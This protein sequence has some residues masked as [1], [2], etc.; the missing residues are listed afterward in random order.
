M[1]PERVWVVLSGG[2]ITGGARGEGN[3]AQLGGLETSKPQVPLRNCLCMALSQDVALPLE[4]PVNFP[5]P[6]TL[7]PILQ[8]CVCTSKGCRRAALRHQ[9]WQSHFQTD[10]SEPPCSC[11]TQE[12]L[13]PWKSP[14]PALSDTHSSLHSHCHAHRDISEHS[15][16]EICPCTASL[17]VLTQTSPPPAS[18]GMG[19]AKWRRFGSPFSTCSRAAWICPGQAEGAAQAI[20]D[21]SGCIPAGSMPF[22]GPWKCLM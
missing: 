6:P 10:L 20:T 3:R 7:P 12:K 9:T 21:G 4:H 5:P 22:P 2:C 19:S 1:P 8:G 16:T 17:Q 14:T 15:R 18:S 13:L 11:H